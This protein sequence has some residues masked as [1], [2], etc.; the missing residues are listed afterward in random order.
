MR[1]TKPAP[2][3][4]VQAIARRI[5]DDVVRVQAA[6]QWQD[7]SSRLISI[8]RAARELLIESHDTP[9]VVEV[10]KE[11]P[12]EEAIANGYRQAVERQLEGA[13]LLLSRIDDA[14]LLKPQTI[15]LCL[16]M[17][18]MASD[19]LHKYMRATIAAEMTWDNLVLD[20][21]ADM[22]LHQRRPLDI[23]G[24]SQDQ[25]QQEVVNG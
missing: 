7:I 4:E 3:T 1:K 23:D 17:M 22:G 6:S 8:Q 12:L 24:Q 11:V 15:G 10:E 2:E 14:N 5:V 20:A 16:M 21:E 25:D 19:T 9:A 18:N 13:A